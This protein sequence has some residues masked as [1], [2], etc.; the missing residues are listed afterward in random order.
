MLQFE[1]VSQSPPPGLIHVTVASKARSSSS[2]RA[3]RKRLRSRPRR[4]P[5]DADNLSTWRTAILPVH[6]GVA[7]GLKGSDQ[8]SK[9]SI[10]RPRGAD[11]SARASKSPLLKMWVNV[12]DGRRPQILES[13]CRL[14]ILTGQVQRR[15]RRSRLRSSQGVFLLF[16]GRLRMLGNAQQGRGLVKK[17]SNF[18]SW[19]FFSAIPWTA[20]SYD[21]RAWSLS[22]RRQWAMARKYQLAGSPPERSCSAFSSA[23]IAARQSPTRNLPSRAYSSSRRIG[24]AA[25]WPSS[26]DGGPVESRA[27]HC[28]DWSPQ[29]SQARPG[30]RD[31]RVS[32]PAPWP[33]GTLARLRPRGQPFAG[34]WPVL[35]CCMP[36]HSGSCG[37]L[38]IQPPACQ[39]VRLH[40]R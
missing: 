22:P 33:G 16:S 35:S 4:Q 36:V 8:T 37:W 10:C 28:W 14:R 20:L 38:G 5:M 39:K 34:A 11:P 18:S 29:P 24:A 25:R 40:W 17:R 26:Q 30:L 12:K 32:P 31:R 7:P 2:L 27:A 6:A 13:H 21:R 15:A 9:G 23:S 3:G 19:D 1:G